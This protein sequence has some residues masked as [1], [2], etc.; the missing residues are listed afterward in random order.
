MSDGKIDLTV[1][2]PNVLWLMSK[3][4]VVA[5]ETQHRSNRHTQIFTNLDTWLVLRSVF[6]AKLAQGTN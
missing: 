3:L 4:E 5:D 1:F 2:G 6:Y